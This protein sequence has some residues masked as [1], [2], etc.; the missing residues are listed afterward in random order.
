M[1]RV[2]AV[3]QQD[4]IDV[5]VNDNGDIAIEQCDDRM[6][7]SVVAVAPAHVERLI[8]ALRAAKRQALEAP[9]A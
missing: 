6:E 9:S 1:S 5:F 2:T 7:V 8:K 3:P 4:A